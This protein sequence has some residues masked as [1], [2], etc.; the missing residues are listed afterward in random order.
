MIFV[1][2]FVLNLALSFVTTDNDTAPECS[3]N[4]EKLVLS[5]TQELQDKLIGFGC[6]NCKD[7]LLK[8]M[9]EL[10]QSSNRL[11]KRI[12][13]KITEYRKLNKHDRG[14]VLMSLYRS[15]YRDQMNYTE[16]STFISSLGLDS[17]KSIEIVNS[18]RKSLEKIYPENYKK[19]YTKFSSQNNM[20]NT[21][22]NNFMACGVY[23]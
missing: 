4:D 5:D 15:Y 20:N 19:F 9:Q 8:G 11:T 7:K 2:M 3:N 22:F 23:I 13:S 18:F 12:L 14:E 16:S 10:G 6:V 1:K 17:S 21:N